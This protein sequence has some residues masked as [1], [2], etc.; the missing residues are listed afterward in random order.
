MTNRLPIL[1]GLTLLSLTI[2]GAACVEGDTGESEEEDLV[3][4]CIAAC[5][6]YLEV[7]E[8]T[9]D[10][11]EDECKDSCVDSYTADE[12]GDLFDSCLEDATSCD[13]ATACW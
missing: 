3:M 4:S 10:Y 7:C 9:A 12:V 11:G 2:I 13:A 6:V 1:L 8:P 5:A